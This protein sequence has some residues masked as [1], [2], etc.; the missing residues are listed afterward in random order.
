MTDG[1]LLIEVRGNKLLVIQ[2]GTTYVVTYYKLPNSPQLIAKN[3]P[4]ENDK[5]APMTQSQFV[6][7]AWQLANDKARE[8]GWIV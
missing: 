8:F 4:R 5:R 7:R 2:P 6:T 3:F 1:D